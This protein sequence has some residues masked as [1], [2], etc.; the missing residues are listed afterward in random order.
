MKLRIFLL[1]FCFWLCL[2][3]SG[4]SQNIIEFDISVA[5]I[6]IGEMKATKHTSLGKELLEIQSQVR[7]WFFTWV[8]LKFNAESTYQNGYLTNSTSQTASNKG[9]F[10]SSVVWNGEKYLVQA[11]SY[12]FQ[13]QEAIPNLVAYS[14]SKLYFE[15][16]KNH[17]VFL[18]ENFGLLSGISKNKDYY[19]V[20]VNGNRNKFYYENGQF[21]K[22]VMQSPIKNYVVSRKS[23]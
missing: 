16:P 17:Q 22:A 6:K 11:D 20:E 13:N 8:D 3:H 23:N 15:E 9:D 2:V 21:V 5:G 14:T 1:V 7:F 10:S 18:A 19:E 4:Q 12:K